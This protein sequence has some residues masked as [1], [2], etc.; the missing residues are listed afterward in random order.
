[1]LDMFDSI[2]RLAVND[3][4]VKIYEL[5]ELIPDVEINLDNSLISKEQMKKMI[6][7]INMISKEL[8]EKNNK[9]QL[10]LQTKSVGKPKTKQTE[11]KVK[12]SK[13]GKP[14]LEQ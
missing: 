11:I 1:M 13:P 5:Y 3:Q 6:N 14:T 7:D 4:I 9:K 2:L 12:Q 10:L 8:N